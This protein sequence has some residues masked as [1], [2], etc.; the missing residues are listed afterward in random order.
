MKAKNIG[1]LATLAMVVTVGGVYATWNYAT[2]SP[3]A[4]NLSTGN[5]TIN[6]ATTSAS[7]GTLTAALSADAEIH[8]K[9]AGSYQA[10]LEV[11]GKLTVNFAAAADAEPN[12]NDG[13]EIAITYSISGDTFEVD[14]AEQ[15]LFTLY[16]ETDGGAVKNYDNVTSLEIPLSE[17]FALN[18][19]YD[20]VLE[21]YAQYQTF[22][23]LVNAAEITISVADRG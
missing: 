6:S 15:H 9:N 11:T 17:V 16:T 19:S 7:K 5:F 23:A 3:A 8:V 13:L 12:T 4:V 21:T 20:T 1:L 22:A 14:D 18:S 10:A 2:S